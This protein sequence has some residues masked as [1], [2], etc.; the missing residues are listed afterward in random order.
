[1]EYLYGHSRVQ[2]VPIDDR[3]ALRSVFRRS[4][5]VV[6]DFYESL[7]PEVNYNREVEHRVTEYVRTRPPFVYIASRKGWNTFVYQRVDVQSRA[8]AIARDLDKQR[9]ANVYETTF[10]LIAELGLPLRLG[11]ESPGSDSALAGLPCTEAEAAWAKLVRQNTDHRRIALLCPFGGA[12]P[13]KAYA[14]W[15]ISALADEIRRLI[16]Q[17]F[18]LVGLPLGTPWGSEAHAR[19]GLGHL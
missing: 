2:L 11:E 5:D 10:R 15:N 12:E 19:E 1:R 14:D 4:F 16:V 17:G 8:Y 3:R 7:V 13:L 6:I 9:V 18:Y